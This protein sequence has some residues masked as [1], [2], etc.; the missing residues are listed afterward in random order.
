MSSMNKIIEIHGQCVM[1]FSPMSLTYAISILI[2]EADSDLVCQPGIGWME[3]NETLQQ[4]GKHAKQ[5]TL[6]HSCIIALGRHTII[7]PRTVGHLTLYGRLTVG[8]LVRSRSR[9]NYR[10]HDEYWLFRQYASG[11]RKLVGQTLTCRLRQR[12]RS[13]MV[14]QKANGSST[15]Y[16]LIFLTKYGFI[17]RLDRRS[18]FLLEK[19]SRLVN[20]LV[21]LLL[22]LTLQSCSSVPRAL[23]GSSRKVISHIFLSLIYSHFVSHNPLSP[24]PS[25]NGRCR[26]FPGC[27]TRIRGRH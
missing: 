15:Q 5:S 11:S 6:R 16:A 19:S 24:C 3:I 22:V 8:C 4:K 26:A 25:N 10:W 2:T 18:S 14:L 20:A 27:Q 9:G 17:N 21:N 12:M 7:L 13:V 1:R 23:L